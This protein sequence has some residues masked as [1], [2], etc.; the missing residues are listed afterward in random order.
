M[1]HRP[2]SRS[3]RTV[4][5]RRDSG[6]GHAAGGRRQPSSQSPMSRSSKRSSRPHFR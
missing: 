2:T 5:R 1:G 4:R 6:T 3:S